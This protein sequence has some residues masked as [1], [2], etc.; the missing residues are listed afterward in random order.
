MMKIKTSSTE[1]FAITFYI[2]A[3]LPIF[4]AE[5]AGEKIRLIFSSFLVVAVGVSILKVKGKAIVNKEG[6]ILI[7]LLIISFF[8]MD[9]VDYKEAHTYFS[10]I[11]I[12]WL[13]Y[14][15]NIFMGT[16]SKERLVKCLLLIFFITAVTSSIGV[17]INNDAA[18]TIAHA[19]SD[20]SLQIEISKKNIAG[21]YLFQA[22]VCA[23]PAIVTILAYLKKNFLIFIYLL[24]MLITLINASFSI[25]LLVF[26]ALFIID[27]FVKSFQQ[28]KKIEGIWKLI[29]V[30]LFIILFVFAGK[31]IMLG[32]SEMIGVD[33]VAE[34]ITELST[35][36]FDSSNSVMTGDATERVALYKASWNTFLNHW[37][38]GV[39][40][41]YSFVKFQ[42]GI[43]FHSQI[44]DDLARFG[45]IAIAFYICFFRTY[46]K[47]L[48]KNWSLLGT[49]TVAITITIA[50]MLF[51]LLN[52]GFRSH[53][54]S[55]IM[56]LVIPNLPLLI[57]K[58]QV[59][60]AYK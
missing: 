29:I 15:L 10:V 38:F 49:N 14:F 35:I 2:W 59:K 17:L 34:R 55:V 25:A 56:F 30:V 48:K 28:V 8:V 22:L 39:G 37:L 11:L 3:L 20:R 57:E 19:I 47:L 50:Y 18:R 40:P 54:E 21:I 7:T 9:L 5:Y 24:L 52:L 46:Y 31:K 26:F 33:K 36:L 27:L 1:I 58:H 44:L 43:G 32:F 23:T 13:T 51:L 45:I 4:C 60:S 6:M 16:K 53:Y 12:F 41:Y 42:N